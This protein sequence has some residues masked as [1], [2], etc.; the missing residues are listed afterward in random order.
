MTNPI[1]QIKPKSNQ[2]SIF[3]EKIKNRNLSV[4]PAEVIDIISDSSHPKYND[5][6]DIGIIQFISFEG[7]SGFA[8]PKNSYL[9]T[10]PLLHESV[11]IISAPTDK[12]NESPG[13]YS[14]YYLDVISTWKILNFNPSPYSSASEPDSQ[15]KSQ[16][17]STFSGNIQKGTKIEFGNYFESKPYI[18]EILPFEG[19]VLLQGRWGNS[20]RLG[21]INKKGKNSWS[22]DGTQGNPIMIFRLNGKESNKVELKTEDINE[23]A[24]SFYLGEGIK[25]PLEQSSDKKDTFQKAGT[26]PDTSKKFIGNQILLTSDRLFFN[27]KKDSIILSSKKTITLTAKETINIDAEKEIVFDGN[28]IY[29]GAKAQEPALL[30]DTSVDLIS[31]LLD[32]ILQL[33]VPTGTGPSGVPINAAIF[34]QLKQKLD[35]LK[36]KKVFIQ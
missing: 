10:P 25:I 22:D 17:Y 31:D 24:T 29:A 13:R 14:Y 28:K 19:D 8:Y 23:D 12:T 36:S 21:S 6:S 2:V 4:F 34:T 15:S 35:T 26:E 30:G 7:P 18:P 1:S 5:D 3:N 33:T 27:S 11:I 16:N 32:G 9:K 20:I